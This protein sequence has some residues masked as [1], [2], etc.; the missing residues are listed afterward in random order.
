[1]KIKKLNKAKLEA[2]PYK[3]VAENMIIDKINEIVLQLN[4]LRTMM[5]TLSSV[6]NNVKRGIFR[7][8][9]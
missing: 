4:R 3:H 5:D 7:N 8:D 6:P 9:L 1:M 2:V